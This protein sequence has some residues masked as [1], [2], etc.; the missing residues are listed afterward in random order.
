MKKK[1]EVISLMLVLLLS[2]SLIITG[3]GKSDEKPDTKGTADQT[4]TT[5]ETSTTTT[6]DITAEHVK[7]KMYFLG[8]P[9]PDNEKVFAEI[10][11]KLTE[12]IN[13]ELEPAYLSWGDWDKRYSLLFSSGEDFDMIYTANWAFYSETASKGGF[14]EL[15]KEMLETYCPLTMQNLPSAA[16]SGTQIKGKNYMIPNNNYFANHYGVIIRGDLREKYGLPEIKT[17]EDVEKFMD[18][19]LKNE[20]GMIPLNVSRDNCEMLMRAM[21]MYPNERY[22]IAGGTTGTL[23]YDITDPKVFDLKPYYE[24]TGYVDFLKRMHEWNKKGYLSKSDLTTANTERFEAGKSAVRF[25]NIG[26]ANTLWQMAKKD[27]PDWKIEYVNLLEGKK[28]GSAGFTGN[29]CAFNARTKNI[30]RALMA[31]DLLNYDPDINF[32]INYGIP[33]V[34]HK[35]AGTTKVGEREFLKVEAID[36]N[37]FGGISNWCFANAPVLPTES[38]PGYAELTASYFYDQISYHPLDGFPFVTDAVNTEIANTTPIIQE[39][40]PIMY[41]GFNDDPEKTLNEFIE[42]IKAAGIDKINEEITNQAKVIFDAAQ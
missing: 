13:A 9:Q 40:I 5:T 2:F 35:I 42:K 16:W 28:L 12:K 7:L 4:G 21:V 1:L 20:K 27:H 33:G 23:T 22:Y 26:A 31:A 15:T 14:Y 36:A 10:S 8:E 24:M 37:G 11:K 32:L 19:V 34:H 17:I 39:Y 30:E 41:M 6:E 18:E 38:F 29:G 25:D 3:C